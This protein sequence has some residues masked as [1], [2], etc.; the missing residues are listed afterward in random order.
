M[1]IADYPWVRHTPDAAVSAHAVMEV[2]GT[3]TQLGEIVYQTTQFTA[4]GNT[5]TKMVLINGPMDVGSGE[6]GVACSGQGYPVAATSGSTTNGAIV[7]PSDS[8]WTLST[9]HPGFV[10]AGAGAIAGTA[11]VLR[12]AQSIE[13]RGWAT[14][15]V[16][17]GDNFTIDNVKTMS[18]LETV[19]SSSDTLSI[20]NTF[21]HDIDDNGFVMAKYNETVAAY[22]GFQAECPA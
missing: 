18:G 20:L 7:G 19:A 13:V 12:Q 21:D 16:A 11:M 3:T 17:N 4:G 14:A 9:G 5:P 6:Y 1:S 22:N 15:A 8:S 2:S 10:V